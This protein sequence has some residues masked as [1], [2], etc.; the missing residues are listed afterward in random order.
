MNK[1]II[2]LAASVAFSAPATAGEFED[3]ALSYYEADAGVKISA[4]ERYALTILLADLAAVTRTVAEKRN[5]SIEGAVELA[6]REIG[7]KGK[8]TNGLARALYFTSLCA[9]HIE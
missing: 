1:V 8:L 4:S 3:C 6:V 5:V 2:A 7:R 9:E